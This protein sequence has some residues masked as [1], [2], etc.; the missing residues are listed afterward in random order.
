MNTNKPVLSRAVFIR[1][2]YHSSRRNQD[3]CLLSFTTISSP[4]LEEC[5]CLLSLDLKIPVSEGRQLRAFGSCLK[6]CAEADLGEDR[7]ARTRLTRRGPDR[8]WG[9]VISYLGKLKNLILFEGLQSGQLD[10][11]CCSGLCFIINMNP[12]TTVEMTYSHLDRSL[13]SLL[14]CVFHLPGPCIQH[15]L[16]L[17]YPTFTL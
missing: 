9:C 4:G 7:D 1:T 6:L 16:A 17:P 5:S 10:P 12:F 8:R 2:S 11:V 3:S 15:H 14:I 13:L